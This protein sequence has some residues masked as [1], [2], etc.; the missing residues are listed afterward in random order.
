MFNRTASLAV[1]QSETYYSEQA[2]WR[3]IGESLSDGWVV[4]EPAELLPQGEVVTMTVGASTIDGVELEPVTVEFQ[5][6][7]G[8]GF[9]EPGEVAVFEDARIE[10]LPKI[11]AT[12]ASPVYRIGPSGVFDEPQTD[13][14]KALMAA[15]FDIATAP[16]G[17]V[18]E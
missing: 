3:A 11:L 15:A 10:S 1:V 5:V 18:S 8:T 14:T 12:A 13:Y 16:L 7:E 9:E 6:G 2:V 17:A 4:H